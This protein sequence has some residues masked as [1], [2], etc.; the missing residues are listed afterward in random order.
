MFKLSSMI[1]RETFKNAKQ[2]FFFLLIHWFNLHQTSKNS[3]S[4]NYQ[5]LFIKTRRQSFNFVALN[6]LFIRWNFM[7]IFHKTLCN[8]LR[9]IL[10]NWL[11]LTNDFYDDYKLNSIIIHVNNI[12]ETLFRF[13]DVKKILKKLLLAIDDSFIKWY[14]KNKVSHFK[15]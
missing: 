14:I 3:S 12:F 1:L 6:S 8:L 5:K 13:I 10:K 15:T 11:L 7:I 2:T 9:F 4:S